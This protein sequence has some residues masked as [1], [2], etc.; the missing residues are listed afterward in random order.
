ML[1]QLNSDLLSRTQ[2]YL[3]GGTE[4]RIALTGQLEPQLPVPVLSQV[5]MY[6]EKPLAN[7]D[8]WADRSTASRDLI[9][10]G[11]MVHHWGA[12]PPEAW[13]KAEMAYGESRQRSAST[14]D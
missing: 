8:R 3:G 13:L 6:A 4:D 11:M 14:N 7:T 1:G 12:I 2:C 5:D 9:D 10:V